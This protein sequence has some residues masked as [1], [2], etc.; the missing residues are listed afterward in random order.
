[1]TLVANITDINDKIYDAARAAGRDSDGLAR[2]MTAH[3]VEDT[4]AAGAR[5]A[6][7]RAAGVRVR[8]AD[9]RPDRRA[10]RRRPRLRGRRRRLLPRAHAA[11][12][13]RAVAPRR[14]PDGPGRGRRGRRSQGGPAR[15]RALEG[16]EGGRGHR[17]GLAVGPR[18]ARLA[19]R[20][21]GDG[22]GAARRRV[23]HPRRRDRPRVP[24][25]RERGGADRGRRAGG[26][27][28]GCGCTTACSRPPPARRWPSRSATSAGSARCSTRSGPSRCSCTS[29]AATTGS[30]SRSRP[31]RSRRR[32][33]ACGGSARPGAA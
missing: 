14:R 27:S 7:P 16:A 22:R 8:R 26:R 29:P 6:R 33:A 15:L 28:P 30:R 25:P 4:G 2:E 10:G 5:A 20:V 21:L 31:R 18:P 24:A 32:P 17:L 23:R 12:L 13:R 3:Y 9:R 11:G 1:M 19:H